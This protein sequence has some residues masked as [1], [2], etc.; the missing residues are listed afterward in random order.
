MRSNQGEKTIRSWL[1]IGIIASLLFMG[2]FQRANADWRTDLGV[3]RIGIVVGNDVGDNAARVEPFR[4]AIA[5]ALGMK[6]EIFPAR[7]MV[8]LIEA[9][10][11]SRIEYAI[12]SASAYA[13]TWVLCECVEPL[14]LPMADDQTSMFRSI[15]ITKQSGPKQLSELTI[16]NMAIP[17]SNAVGAYEIALFEL[18]EQGVLPEGLSSSSKLKSSEQALNEF[19]AGKYGAL[20]GWR[21]LAGDRFTGYSRGSLKELANRDG[22]EATAYKVLWESSDIPHSPHAIRKNIPAEAKE[23]LKT[24]LQQISLDDLA[25]YDAIET[26]YG[27]GFALARQDQFSPLV[28]YVHAEL[29]GL[30][31]AVK[32]TGGVVKAETNTGEKVKK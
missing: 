29:G 27:G 13:T 21:S 28:E 32:V 18:K 5:K 19:Y 9:L 12:Y 14:V 16:D 3:F 1:V 17:I 6:V 20:L 25:A 26:Q 15:I 7:N 8:A 11:S 30:D 24:L 23:I 22:G 2:N 31:D 4:L 10:R